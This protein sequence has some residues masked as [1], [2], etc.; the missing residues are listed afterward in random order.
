[1]RTG[2]WFPRCCDSTMGRYTGMVRAFQILWRSLQRLPDVVFIELVD[3]LFTALLPVISIGVTALAVGIFIA[4]REHDA[5]LFA[6]TLASVLVTVARILFIFAYRRRRASSLTSADEMKVWE[7]RYAG[8]SLA[9]IPHPLGSA[10]AR[11]PSQPWQRLP[12][13]RWLLHSRCCRGSLA[14]RGVSQGA[15]R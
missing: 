13:Q 5:T 6:L 15:F 11:E 10:T 4:S 7:R 14:P 9:F 8:G 12:G 1:M 3:I 2:I